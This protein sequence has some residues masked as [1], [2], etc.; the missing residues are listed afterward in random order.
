MLALPWGV[1][2][3]DHDFA[4]R[5]DHLSLRLSASAG[6]FEG[7][8]RLSFAPLDT[9]LRRVDRG[10]LVGAPRFFMTAAPL[11]PPGSTAARP[12]D[13]APPSGAG[14]WF[15]GG[16]SQLLLAALPILGLVAAA[17]GYS[18]YSHHQRESARLEAVAELR[19]SQI[20]S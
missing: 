11:K 10:I 19:S 8:N 13:P 5:P 6:G 17:V 2:K 14:R 3:I 9:H 12:A 20:Q 18:F 4:C 15:R 7:R 1:D 16:G